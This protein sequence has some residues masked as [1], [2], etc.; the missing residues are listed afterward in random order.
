M[1]NI[2]SKLV[3][4]IGIAV[5]VTSCVRFLPI[6]GN[7]N[8][9]TF[10]I[11]V[12]SFEKI[13][14]AGSVEI[15]YYASN[16]YHAVVTIDSNLKEYVEI[17]TKNNVLSIKTKN[18]YSISY[19]RFLV[20]VYCPFVSSVMISG[21]GSFT[22][23]DK[24]TS[25]SFETHISGSGKVNGTIECNKFST[26]ISGSGKITVEGNCNNA[27]I[28]ISGSGNFFGNYFC[29]KNATINISGSGDANLYVTDYLKANISGSGVIKY[30]G[31]PII[32]SNIS[33]SGKIKKM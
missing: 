16:E 28:E 5:V 6:T 19:T 14:S 20:D 25:S 17:D 7:G 27:N 31:N 3:V 11:N 32:E 30:R 29:I 2:Y 22:G 1:K 24:I 33:G 8:L 15:R 18:G 13:S 23:M 26:K 12:S 9:E 10:E 21:S 4:I